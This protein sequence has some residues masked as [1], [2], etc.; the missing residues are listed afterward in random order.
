MGWGV[1]MKPVNAHTPARASLDRKPRD[2]RR[3][4]SGVLDS[5]FGVVFLCSHGSTPV[6]W[7]LI[8]PSDPWELKELDEPNELWKPKEPQKLQEQGIRRT[9]RT[10]E[11][12]EAYVTMGTQG[13]GRTQEAGGRE[14][15]KQLVKP[16]ESKTL[17]EPK[18][19]WEPK[20]KEETKKLEEGRNPRNRCNHGN[21]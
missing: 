12:Q 18:E 4:R 9:A 19:S 21:S 11:T 8:G 7:V 14:E 10:M 15:H 16:W 2:A 13:T 1:A 17:K 5:C 6:P 3:K 20:E